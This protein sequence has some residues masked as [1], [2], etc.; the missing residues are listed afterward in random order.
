[1]KTIHAIAGLPR[2]GSTL[3]CNILNQNPAARA[4]PTSCT[5]GFMRALS[6]V[7]SNR[8]EFQ[9]LLDKFPKHT[10]ARLNSSMQAFFNQWHDHGEEEHIFDKSRGWTGV[11]DMFGQLSPGGVILVCVRDLRDVL[12]SIEKEDRKNGLLTPNPDTPHERYAQHFGPNGVV[13]APLNGVMGLLD[14]KPTNALFIQYERL[15]ADP[16][17]VM[18]AMYL[19]TGM[20]QFE[21]DFDNVPD[22]MSPI[23]PDGFWLNKYPHKASGKIEKQDGHWSD[24]VSETIADDIMKVAHRYNKVFGYA[25]EVGPSTETIDISPCADCSD[26]ESKV[27]GYV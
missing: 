20:P 10:D 16:K 23:E 18:D 1:M 3:L 21:H 8:I 7:A 14:R 27:L 26:E 2:S 17:A 11:P 15:I 12:A 5:P 22:T 9:N 6:T 24:F 4:T 25:E 19:A 13:G